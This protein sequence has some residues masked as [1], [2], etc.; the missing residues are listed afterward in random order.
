MYLF[1][2]TV[3]PYTT[4][5]LMYVSVA[6]FFTIVAVIVSTL[7]I[8]SHVTILGK[9][10]QLLVST[11]P[12][13]LIS[14]V[15]LILIDNNCIVPNA[16]A[17]FKQGYQNPSV[18]CLVQRPAQLSRL[19][20]IL[21]PRRHPGGYYLLVGPHGCGKTTVLQK[22]VAECG[23][24]VMYLPMIPGK[25]VSDVLY[26]A[27]RISEFCK[28]NWASLRSYVGVPSRSC[29][30][31]PSDRFKYALEVLEAAATEIFSEDKSPP[32]LVFDGTEQ[33]LQL[34][35]GVKIIHTLQDL[36]KEISDRKILILLFSSSESSVPNIMLTRSSTSRL[37]ELI[38]VGDISDEQAV[39]YLSCMCPNATKDDIKSAVELVGGRFSD[40]VVAQDYINRGI[41]YDNLKRFFLDSVRA[42]IVALPSWIRDVVYKVMESILNSNNSMITRDEFNDLLKTLNTSDIE[43][44]EKL[45]VLRIDSRIVTFASRVTQHYWDSETKMSNSSRSVDP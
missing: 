7:Y 1:W 36:A 37:H 6:V 27:L 4:S 35:G 12:I 31:T 13:I 19:K 41:G 42:L 14:V 25:D 45:N 17:T 40:L 22:A 32:S 15:A 44:I 28:S 39:E 38:T 3:C 11:V 23:S 10:R 16:K 43:L 21:K 9:I 29:P 34:V 20:D 5:N 26:S 2:D 33:I 8:C 30:K 18:E 24:G